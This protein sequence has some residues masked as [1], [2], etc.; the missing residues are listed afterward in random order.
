M[1]D[2]SADAATA[3]YMAT[4]SPSAHAIATAYTHGGHWI[5]LWSWIVT[6]IA[7]LLI[8]RAEFLS[9]IRNRLERKGR[10]HPN[11]V[12]LFSAVGFLVADFLIELPWTVYSQW[13]R[14]QS[15]GLTTQAFAGWLSENIL[16][17]VI[18]TIFISVVLVAVYALIRRAPRTW[19][20]WSG[21]VATATFLFVRVISPVV[22]EP[23][24][25]TYSPAPQGPVRDA[26]V[27]LATRSGIPSDKIFV[28]NGSKQ[29]EKYT[30]N[31]AGLFGTARIALSDTMFRTGADLSEIKAVVGH[32]M[33]H[34]TH[35]HAL[36]FAVALGLLASFAFF[37]CGRLF[38]P[39]AAA[40]SAPLK[41][42]RISDPAGLPVLMVILGTI[43]LA[44]VPI[45][46][47]MTRY[48]ESDADA[49]SL[50]LAHE[51]DGMAKALVKTITYRASSPSRLE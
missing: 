39:T 11:W 41:A 5:L 28:Y 43:Q 7:A 30:A 4:L 37:L 27:S 1:G 40:M 24:F 47:T 21:A 45:T 42:F 3:A 33:G 13:W 35:G 10:P 26:V 9:W 34:Y 22:I 12:V 46:N 48:E 17:T 36:V 20:I 2:A 8:F 25:N 49:F 16:S 19:W 15:Y 14:E 51:P 18:S 38:K 31:V 32:E 50:S 6:V 23:L 29:S 44:L